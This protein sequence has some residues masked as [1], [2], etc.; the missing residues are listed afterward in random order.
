MQI[1][2]LDESGLTLTRAHV[3]WTEA[4]LPL[5]RV[6]VLLRRCRFHLRSCPAHVQFMCAKCVATKLCSIVCR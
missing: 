6:L 2:C 3:I 1:L 5:P 4:C